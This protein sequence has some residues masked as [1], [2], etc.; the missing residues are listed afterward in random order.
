MNGSKRLLP[1]Y[2]LK[3]LERYSDV[4]HPLTQN[5]VIA[6][7]GADYGMECERKSIA[8]N[9]LALQESGYDIAYENGYY[10]RER[11]FEDSELRL[12]ID[13]VLCSRDIP[14][15]QCRHLIEKLGALS[16]VYFKKSI[17]HI[18]N[19]SALPHSPNKE[20]FYTIDVLDEAIE[21][22]RQVRFFYNKFGEDKQL[23]HLH[24]HPSTVNP[25]QMAVSNG[26]YYLIGNYDAFDNVVHCRI[27]FITEITMLDAPAKP[28]EQVRG[29]ENGLNLPKHLLEHLYMFSGE[30]VHVKM[31]VSMRIISD[32]IDW[33]GMEF[34]IVREDDAHCIVQ[35]CVNA[36]AMYY[37]AM[38]Y[39]NYVEILEPET[40]RQ[41]I[42]E[43]ARHLAAVYEDQTEKG[44]AL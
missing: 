41:R 8:R 23:H 17:R 22:K 30:S 9:I 15:L 19:V 26:R 42:H 21:K 40:L 37:W 44:P 32:V 20:L 34:H 1:L 25:Y 16:N 7:L 43:T 14:V 31:R 12:L 4:E 29:L 36:Q 5:D 35:L 24:H 28:M 6:H 13:R 38:Q 33:F 18:C 27:D 39:G 2:I 3:I 11:M 10:L